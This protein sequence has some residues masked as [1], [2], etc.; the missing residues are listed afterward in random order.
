MRI[1]NLTAGLM[2]LSI[3]VASAPALAQNAASGVDQT[4]V[5][6]LVT[7]NETEIAQARAQ[8][9]SSSNPGVV[10]FAKTMIT[11]HTTNNTQVMAM[12]RT[13]G[14]T[15]PTG[16]LPHGT[17][18]AGISA[19]DYMAL[20]VREHQAALGLLKGE[21]D[22]G[23][24]AQL[25]TFAAQT[26]PVVQAHLDMAQQYVRTGTVSPEVTPTPAGR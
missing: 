10:L 2:A 22:N 23:G 3:A 1:H 25:R 17:A 20:Q 11:D 16:K 9:R 8:L 7:A 21:A 19:S 13:L 18:M 15:Y 26:M 4:F 6:Q 5:N 14:L 24:S 12:A